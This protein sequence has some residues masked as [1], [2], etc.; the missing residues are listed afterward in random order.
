MIYQ[1]KREQQLY[2]DIQ[3]AWDF[4]SSPHNLSRITPKEMDFVV[5]SDLPEED[6]YKG[7]IIDYT[8]SPVLGIPLK[9]RTQ[10][11]AVN[12]QKSFTDFQKKG[13]YKLWRHHHEFI[14]NQNGVL[15]VDTV[16]YELPFGIIGKMVHSLMVKK[17]LK[18]IFDHRYQVLEA[19]FKLIKH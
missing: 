12:Y 6:I 1:L 7:M 10:I 3:T 8:V 5:L 17:K 18:H 4:F 2:C 13:P 19:L 9:W 14:P 15:M 11:T 16:D